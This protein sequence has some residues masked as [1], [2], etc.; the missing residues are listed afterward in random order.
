LEATIIGE[1]SAEIGCMRDGWEKS[2]ALK[3]HDTWWTVVRYFWTLL[4]FWGNL[5]CHK[6]TWRIW[7]R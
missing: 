7:A 3:A 6:W 1:F 2:R 5:F 4:N